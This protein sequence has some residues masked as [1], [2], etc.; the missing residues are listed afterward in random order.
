ME[1]PS[2]RL[3]TCRRRGRP[4]YGRAVAILAAS[5]RSAIWHQTASYVREP[6]PW[7]AVSLPPLGGIC[8]FP[9]AV[10]AVIV[11]KSAS[12]FPWV[13]LVAATVSAAAALGGV[14]LA[15]HRDDRNHRGDVRREAY[16]ELAAAALGVHDAFKQRWG[17]LQRKEVDLVMAMELNRQTDELA[18]ALHRAIARVL[19]VAPA[20]Q[21]ARIAGEINFGA[22][23]EVSGHM[24]PSSIV[25]GR[26]TWRVVSTIP[27]ADYFGQKVDEF[28]KEAGQDIASRRWRRPAWSSVRRRTG[29]QS[30]GSGEAPTPGS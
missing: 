25:D 9:I 19:I 28:V 17:M 24:S 16:A 7:V 12:G 13:T 26:Q 23:G 11:I 29:E 30:L 18:A 27:G 22:N 5:D 6:L 10:S 21:L 14:G 3:R 4:H 2:R 15:G 1:L 8:L 20:S